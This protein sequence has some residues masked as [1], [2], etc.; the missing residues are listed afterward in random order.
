MF[1]RF[2]KNLDAQIR[3]HKNNSDRSVAIIGVILGFSIESRRPYK[4]HTPCTTEDCFLTTS[5]LPSRLEDCISELLWTHDFSTGLTWG[6]P[7]IKKSIVVARNSNL[8]FEAAKPD[9]HAGR[10][11]ATKDLL[12]TQRNTSSLLKSF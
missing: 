12:M 9:G 5:T 8:K 6:H 10:Y 1:A 3:I 4:R 11:F 2:F 7:N